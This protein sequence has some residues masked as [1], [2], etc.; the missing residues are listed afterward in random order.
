MYHTSNS[1]NNNLSLV[2][3]FLA[4]AISLIWP[5]SNIGRVK[6]STSFPAP[7][8]SVV[9]ELKQRRRRRQR[10]QQKSNRLRLAK[11]QLCICITLCCTFLWRDVKMS[12]FTSCEGR[13][14]KTTIFLFLYWIS[15]QSLRIQLQKKNTN[16]WRIEGDGISAIKFEAERLHILSD[17]FVAIAIVVV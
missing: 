11:Q 2:V 3:L 13:E 7:L 5:R 6:S 10:G 9:R 15:I 14:H 17:V 4:F 12:N 1:E 16:I 8:S